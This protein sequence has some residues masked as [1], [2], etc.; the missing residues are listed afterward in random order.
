MSINIGIIDARVRKLAEVLAGEFE[1]RLK[2]PAAGNS[3][4]E[5]KRRSTAFVYLCVKTVLDLADEEALDCL[6]EGG[7]DFGVDA[8]HIGDEEDGEFV[9]T[10][11]QGK[12]T[13]KMEKAGKSN[14]EQGA[15]EKAIQAIRYLF[16]P[17]AVITTNPNLT[18]RLEEIRSLVRD[19][20]IPRVNFVLCSNGLR[21]NDAT[22]Q[23][24]DCAAFPRDQVAWQ[25]INHDEIVHLLQASK[26]VNDVLRLTGKATVE[27]FDYSRVLVG[28]IPVQEIA[29][30]FNRHGDL[31]LERNVRRFLGMQANRVNEG[32]AQTL[33][34]E[35]ERGNFYFY[36][37]GLTFL[38]QKFTYNALQNDN[39]QVH[40]EGLQVI[41]GGQ[42]CKTIQSTLALL[43]GAQPGLEKAFVLV[44]LYQLPS[45]SNDLVRSI[46]YATNSQNPV[47]LRD[48]R[49]NDFRQKSLE[50]AIRDLGFAY[51]RYRSDSSL[52][53]TD[54]SSATAAEA[55]LSVWRGRPH[56]G[57]FHGREHFGKLYDVI[58]TDDLNA[59]QVVIA[60]LLF[61]SAENKRRRPPEGSPDFIAYASCFLAMLMGRY[62]LS[63]L[64][65][66]LAELDHRKFAEA[67]AMLEENEDA[68]HQRAVEA[69]HAALA[70]LY[71]DRV[72]LQRLAATFRRG[73]LI[74]LL[75]ETPAHE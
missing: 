72:S 47:D 67:K 50:T 37:N 20:H 70:R 24:I 34:T 22:Q 7:N 60:T 71:A 65:I 64:G 6:T 54:I 53:S 46:T 58:F 48:L 3:E 8:I 52:K 5:T 13:H 14:F 63:D 61:R 21:W 15:V 68:Y 73:D 42:T 56:Q 36:N 30:L 2:I 33:N 9:V 51:H 1:L 57:K 75:A 18:K 10:L 43:A 28:K 26:P 4:V 55:V 27:D 32:I 74:E 38:C 49:S 25:Y 39:Y 19:G 40:V 44:R 17:N 69:I 11:F 35:S 41:N 12:Y 45:D 29:A 23:I 59:A 62:L 66:T 16:D 31:L